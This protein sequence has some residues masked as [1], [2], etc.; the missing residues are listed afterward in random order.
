MRKAPARRV[1]RARGRPPVRAACGWPIAARGPVRRRPRAARRTPGPAPPR[2]RGPHRVPRGRCPRDAAPAPRRFRS[3][4]TTSAARGVRERK[5]GN[6]WD[7]Y[8]PSSSPATRWTAASSSRQVLRCSARNLPALRRQVVVP[9]AAL[10]CL[11]DPLP[12]DP[13][14]PLHAI[15]HRVQ[16]GDVEAQHAVG[17][18]VDALG[19]VVSVPRAALDRRE[20]H[21]LG[22][23]ALH[24]SVWGHILRDTICE[25]PA[26]CQEPN[27]RSGD[28]NRRIRGQEVHCSL[29]K[30]KLL[31][32]CSPVGSSP[33]LLY[34][35]GC[36][37]NTSQRTR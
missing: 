8:R 2:D 32:T 7:A 26:A 19:D 35:V 6:P 22:A 36:L 4:G 31:N 16:G 25:R 14:A 29:K 11:L 34:I 20:H 23:P 17:S 18:I 24:V 37:H 3:R 9:A 27:R 28:L 30:K 10:P 21:E 12:V 5:H 1:R 15:Q 33:V 13:A